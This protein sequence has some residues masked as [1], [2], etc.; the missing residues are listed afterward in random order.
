MEKCGKMC[1]NGEKMWKNVEKCEKCAGD[2]FLIYYSHKLNSKNR[3]EIQ[4]RRY[5]EHVYNTNSISDC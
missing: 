3:N 2:P 4:N 1:E 5:K